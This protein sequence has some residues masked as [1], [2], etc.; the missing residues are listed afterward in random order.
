MRRCTRSG[1]STTRCESRGEGFCSHLCRIPHSLSRCIATLFDLRRYRMHPWMSP[2]HFG[3]PLTVL[4]RC[5]CLQNASH[6]IREQ[7]Q[8]TLDHYTN[9][10]P[11]SQLQVSAPRLHQRALVSA[12]GCASAV[13]NCCLFMFVGSQRLPLLQVQHLHLGTLPPRIRYTS[14]EESQVYGEFKINVSDRQPRSVLSRLSRAPRCAPHRKRQ[15][16]VLLRAPSR[17]A[18]ERQQHL[19]ERQAFLCLKQC[20]GGQA[21][22]SMIAPEAAA[23]VEAVLQFGGL[24]VALPIRVTELLV[25]CGQP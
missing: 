12:F 16:V 9:I 3:C 24:R 19:K 18:I 5:R 10:P 1:R 25:R 2:V 7:I 13:S 21:E 6:Y 23:V 14:F 17:F 8:A 11:L 15:S 22:G 4:P 20:L